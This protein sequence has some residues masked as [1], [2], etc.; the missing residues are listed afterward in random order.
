LAIVA[1][2]AGLLTALL[3]F[4]LAGVGMGFANATASG[5]GMAAVFVGLWT[6]LAGR[7]ISR[8]RRVTYLGL[9][10]A[11]LWLLIRFVWDWPATA[12]SGIVVLFLVPALSVPLV[13][14]WL[15]LVTVA[16]FAGAVRSWRMIRHGRSCD[17]GVR[18]RSR[19]RT[20]TG[21]AV[22]L[23]VLMAMTLL[24]PR[25]VWQDRGQ[26]LQALGEQYAPGPQQAGKA[27][28]FGACSMVFLGYELTQHAPTGQGRET[29]REAAYA[30]A[31]RDANAEL[32][33]LVQAGTKYVRVGASGD[34]M[35]EDKPDQERVD[36][37]YVQRIRDTGI[38]LVL[39]DTQHPKALR[40]R[41]LGWDE[42]CQFQQERIAYYQRCYR[43]QVYFV[44]CEPLSYHQF[45]LAKDV[46]F[47]AEA[48]ANQLAAMCRLVKSLDAGTQTGICLLVTDD[49]KGEWDVWTRMKKSPEL[50]ILSVE[51]YE[52][53][54]FQQ[55]QQRLAEYGHPRETG[56]RFWIAETYNGWALCGQRHWEQD[57]AWLRLSSGFAG[58]VEAD[59]VLVWSFG[60]FVPGG[61]FWDF[62]RGKLAERWEARRELSVVGRTFA[63]VQSR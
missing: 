58:V 34:Q 22:R 43:P 46:A 10:L 13:A 48:W 53:K 63:E 29:A 14:I 26:K 32:A 12:S 51:I 39:V 17:T 54:N 44:V 61:S 15:I 55:T 49:H 21:L 25:L 50:D 8:C 33:S 24:V 59:T 37:Q 47:S 1:G 31:L 52:P 6:S 41:K 18:Q 20:A 28:V 56:K 35:L 38:P 4:V 2:A 9:S 40:N 36:D 57:A 30:S 45:I 7:G 27:P 5:T 11:W 3:G 62:G 23:A 16:G 19:Y 60:T 42:F